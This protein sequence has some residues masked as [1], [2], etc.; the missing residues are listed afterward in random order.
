MKKSFL[1]FSLLISVTACMVKTPLDDMTPQQLSALPAKEL[2][3]WANLGDTVAIPEARRRQVNCAPEYLYCVDNGFKPGS[4]NFL[5]CI[6]KYNQSAAAERAQKQQYYQE[7]E[8]LRRDAEVC[9]YSTR[10]YATQ[11]GGDFNDCIQKLK[12]YRANPSAP[13]IY[14]PPPTQNTQHTTCEIIAGRLECTTR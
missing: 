7:Q 8:Q 10:A 2:C 9:N 3:Y 4:K 12:Y 5:E 14:T 6:S 13:P 11:P 1:F